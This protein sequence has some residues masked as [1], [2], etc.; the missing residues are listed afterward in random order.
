MLVG[1]R[2][3]SLKTQGGALTACGLPHIVHRDEP[4]RRRAKDDWIFTTP[5]VRVAV[6]I[7]FRMQQ[8]SAL[9]KKFDDLWICLEYIFAAKVFDIEEEISRIVDRTIYLKPVLLPDMK[10]IRA[11]SGRSVDAAG[12]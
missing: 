10:V 7:T 9:A 1:V 11:V 6:L 4:L 8:H 2:F 12:A 3:P 5:A